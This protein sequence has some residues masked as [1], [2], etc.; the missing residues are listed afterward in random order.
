MKKV[1]VKKPTKTEELIHAVA[2]DNSFHS[3]ARIE[4]KMR[5]LACE[6]D[7]RDQEIFALTAAVAT[8][9][10]RKA[11]LEAIRA[12]LGQILDKR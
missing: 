12:G 8:A 7:E 4:S 11:G 3:S 6:I 9:K 5:V 10:K 1:K 2:R